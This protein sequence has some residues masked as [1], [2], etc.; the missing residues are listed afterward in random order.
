MLKKI[1]NELEQNKLG[2]LVGA[3]VGLATAYYL[4]QQ[5]QDLTTLTSAGK[6]LVDSFMDRSTAVDIAKTKM[7]IVFAGTGAII[8]F[9]TEKIVR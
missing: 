1:W 2:I 4:I 8:G 7:Y 6:G 3:G 9:I 5:G